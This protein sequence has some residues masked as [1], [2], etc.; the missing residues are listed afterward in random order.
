MNVVYRSQDSNKDWITAYKKHLQ[1]IPYN[2]DPS[3]KS[4][5]KAQRSSFVLS[6]GVPQLVSSPIRTTKTSSTLIDHLYSNKPG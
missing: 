3:K 1:N 5:Q 2:F 6:N 4:I